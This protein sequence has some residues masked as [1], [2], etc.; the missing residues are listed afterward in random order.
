MKGKLFYV[1]S[2]ASGTI[3]FTSMNYFVIKNNQLTEEE[4]IKLIWNPKI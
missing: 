2:V 1:L 3:L 4:K